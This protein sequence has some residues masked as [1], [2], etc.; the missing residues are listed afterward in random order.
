MPVLNIRFPLPADS[1]LPEYGRGGLYELAS[2]LRTWLHE[3]GAGWHAGGVAP[4]D[5]AAR[6]VLLVIDGLGDRYLCLAGAG[7]VLHAHRRGAL[8]SVCP[9]TT[10]S[11]VTT[12]LT[13]VAPAVH[14]L[15]GWFVHDRR[16]GGVVLPLP[17]GLRAGPPLEAVRLMSRL[18]PVPPMFHH[19]NRPAVLVS[20]ADIAF[21]RF[22]QHHA[23][24]ARIEPYQGLQGLEAQILAQVDRLAAS[25]GLVHAY[26]PVF[27]ALSHLH[28]CRS[29]QVHACFERIDALFA[30][31]LNALAGR[32]VHLVVTAD[33]GFTDSSPQR[34]VDLAPGGEVAAMLA[35]PLFGERRLAFCRVRRG[36]AAEFEAWARVEL[37]GKAV[38]VAGKECRES[39]LL[40]PGAWHPRLAERVGTHVLLM[41]PGWT[42]IDHVEGE[43]FHE[44]IGVHGGLSADEMT[45]PW[46]AVRS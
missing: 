45:V 33:H 31:L 41:E 23:R 1:V 15:N 5:A 10:A 46:I 38:L 36:A 3:P 24:G 27:D 6:V 22:S 13:G 18:C 40:G 20:P 17:L 16:F 30:N 42:I 29:A 19:A 32:G 14:G 11:A 9:S 2:T 43:L 28:G 7:S 44:M 26:Y 21:S 34:T 12:L 8:T 39:G 37:A 4:G 35:A 25:G